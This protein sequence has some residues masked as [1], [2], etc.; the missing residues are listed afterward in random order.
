MTPTPA[1]APAIPITPIRTLVVANRGEIARRIM[2]S[3]HAMGITCVAVFSDADADSP[4]LAE[5]D[6]AVR[7]PGT[8]PADT[9]LRIDLLLEA[10]SRCAADA[11]HPGYGFLSESGDAARAVTGAGLIWV[12]PTAEA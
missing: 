6:L 4:H 12:G 5:A 10:A 11:V 1:P 3:A 9:Y 2:R 7:L 8:S